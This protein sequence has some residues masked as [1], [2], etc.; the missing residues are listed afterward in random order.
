MRETICVLLCQWKSR[1]SMFDLTEPKKK[2]RRIETIT[3]IILILLG[4]GSTVFFKSWEVFLGIAIGGCLS[5]LNLWILAR[6][7]ENL[8]HQKNPR[9]VALLCQ[10]IIKTTILLGGL[11]L[12]L[13][14]MA[15]NIL[16]LALG[17]SAVLLAIA[18]EGFFLPTTQI[19]PKYKEALKNRPT[20]H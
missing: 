5:L 12:L 14:Y 10:Y 7:V 15:I 18:I 11:Y 1:N 4:I 3:I 19:H 16:A 8:F 20:N 17:F 6:I 13:K 9:K 2:L